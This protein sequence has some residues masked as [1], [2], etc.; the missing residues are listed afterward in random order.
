MLFAT[1]FA[2]VYM[3]VLCFVASVSQFKTNNLYIDLGPC[4]TN[5]KGGLMAVK[6]S[7]TDLGIL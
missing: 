1:R 7:Y 3:H 2:R 5:S 6:A 4:T